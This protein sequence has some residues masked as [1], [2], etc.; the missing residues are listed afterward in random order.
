[1]A[2]LHRI[3]LAIA[4]SLNDGTSIP[5][6]QGDRA[7]RNG[8]TALADRQ[9][10]ASAKTPPLLN[11]IGKGIGKF[12][13]PIFLATVLTQAPIEQAGAASASTN[14]V[15]RPLPPRK[16]V[17]PPTSPSTNRVARPPS[18]T[19][20]PT[21]RPPTPLRRMTPS[22]NQVRQIPNRNKVVPPR[23][24]S[25][26]IPTPT[27]RTTPSTNSPAATP[28]PKPKPKPTPT[29]P[30][31]SGIGDSIAG[32]I[33]YDAITG[34]RVAVTP[35]MRGKMTAIP[36]VNQINGTKRRETVQGENNSRFPQLNRGENDG[37]T[38][39]YDNANHSWTEYYVIHWDKI[40]TNPHHDPGDEYSWPF[41]VSDE[42]LADGE[43]F[44]DV[45]DEF[46]TAR[47]MRSMHRGAMKRPKTYSDGWTEWRWA[48]AGE[49][50]FSGESE[51][52]KCE[53]EVVST[54][55]R[56]ADSRLAKSQTYKVGVKYKKAYLTYN[57][58]SGSFD[59]TRVDRKMT[60]FIFKD[61]FPATSNHRKS[62]LLLNEKNTQIVEGPTALGQSELYWESRVE[63]GIFSS[64]RTIW[65]RKQ[66]DELKEKEKEEND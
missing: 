17:V 54:I 11:R 32:N 15:S 30:P 13:I 59:T 14:Q 44:Y 19:T 53:H 29:N 50:V 25:R 22:T 35:P 20:V 48:R 65:E 34:Q 16:K 3:V 12:W 7:L 49:W 62:I 51:R 31:G 27:R 24:P 41:I 1:M 6:P 60:T 23:T 10:Q 5:A 63:D 18:R 46:K 43:G 37:K 45:G 42:S 58:L 64:P 38:V 66:H 2:T 39:A 55:Q 52:I 47:R 33:I 61:E 56:P 8:T 36:S 4:G 57:R 21:Y 9:A 40:V 26:T 28:K